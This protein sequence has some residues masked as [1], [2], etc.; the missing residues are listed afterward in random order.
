[1]A[2]EKAYFVVTLKNSVHVTLS[3][4][5]YSEWPVIRGK[6]DHLLISGCGVLVP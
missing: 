1:M 2:L 6:Q 5:L 4:V 3:T